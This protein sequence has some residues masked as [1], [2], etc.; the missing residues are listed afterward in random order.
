M[1]TQPFVYHFL[2][3]IAVDSS[4]QQARDGDIKA[5]QL[6]NFAGNLA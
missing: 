6:I 5:I 1:I 4:K 3:K 2:K